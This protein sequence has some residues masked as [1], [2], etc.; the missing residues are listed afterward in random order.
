[1]KCRAK[2]IRPKM[3]TVFIMK[4]DHIYLQALLS[5]ILCGVYYDQKLISLLSDKR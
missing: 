3:N 2:N 1:M 4:L 5:S